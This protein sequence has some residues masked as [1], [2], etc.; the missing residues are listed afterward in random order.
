MIKSKILHLF[1]AQA[2]VPMSSRTPIYLEE[3][4]WSPLFSIPSQNLEDTVVSPVKEKLSALLDLKA[5]HPDTKRR[6]G[7]K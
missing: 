2:P 6:P 1:R 3:M 4:E 5:L 7:G